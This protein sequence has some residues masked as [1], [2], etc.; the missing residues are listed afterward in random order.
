MPKKSK[1]IKKK[2]SKN[3]SNGNGPS[4]LD[5]LFLSVSNYPFSSKFFTTNKSDLDGD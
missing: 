3:S 4:F 1:K 2:K 5:K